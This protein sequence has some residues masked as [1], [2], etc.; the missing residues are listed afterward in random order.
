MKFLDVLAKWVNLF[1]GLTIRRSKSVFELSLAEA[2]RSRPCQS[3]STEEIS[4]RAEEMVC[5]RTPEVT[6]QTLMQRSLDLKESVCV[7]TGAMT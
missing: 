3:T 7:R 2:R 1:S 5:T 6:S 4:P